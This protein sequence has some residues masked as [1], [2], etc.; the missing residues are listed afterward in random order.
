MSRNAWLG[1]A[2]LIVVLLVG[3]LLPAWSLRYWEAWVYVVL[4]AA[5]VAAITVYLQRHDPA[6]L[7]RRLAAGPA[8]ERR[9]LQQLVQV[10]TSV[11][12]LG[13]LVV[14]SFDHRLGWSHVP[15]WLVLVGD[16]LV[17]LGLAIVFA[18]FR[19]NTYASATIELVKDQRVIDT[20]PYA[21]VRHPMYAGALVML[22]GTPLGLGSFWG[23]LVLLPMLAALI[24]RLLDEERMLNRDL[25]G[26][27]AYRSRVRARLIPGVW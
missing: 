24:W 3:T 17:L 14:A 2:Q 22:L 11:A 26:Y 19:A 21:L 13:I 8:A 25:P 12:F 4:F 5:S 7:Q 9:R 23:L 15:R 16:G 1:L 18:T 20:G 10:I 6:L 27:S